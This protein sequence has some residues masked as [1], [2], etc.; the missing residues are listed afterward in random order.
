MNERIGKSATTTEHLRSS[1]YW[2]CRVPHAKHSPRLSVRFTTTGASPTLPIYIV[3][4]AQCRCSFTPICLTRLPG[5]TEARPYKHHI[6]NT[7]TAAQTPNNRISSPLTSYLFYT[8]KTE[9]ADAP[10]VIADFRWGKS[11]RVALFALY[12]TITFSILLP[13]LTM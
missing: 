7:L 12:L 10:S 3:P 6:I 1:R 11:S 2:G 4:S 5:R 9:G 8:A 13:A